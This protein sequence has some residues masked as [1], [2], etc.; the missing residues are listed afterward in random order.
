MV[1]IDTQG[2]EKGQVLI[3]DPRILRAESPDLPASSGGK[4]SI[5]QPQ[6]FLFPSPMIP[7]L[8]SYAFITPVGRA[9]CSS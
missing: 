3:P 6:N 4:C 8:P 1:A 5:T 9:R 2:Q 7:Q